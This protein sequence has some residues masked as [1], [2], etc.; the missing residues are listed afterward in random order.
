MQENTD[1]VHVLHVMLNSSV[2]LHVKWT[3]TSYRGDFKC[4]KKPGN[5]A[6]WMH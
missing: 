4:A 2:P 3:K 1:F 5:T 6:V